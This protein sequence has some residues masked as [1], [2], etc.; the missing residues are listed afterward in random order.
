MTG[1]LVA[2]LMLF[3]LLPTALCEAGVPQSVS[4]TVLI[5]RSKS[6]TPLGPG[7]DSRSLKLDG[8]FYETVHGRTSLPAQLTAKQKNNELENEVTMTDGR[9]VKL[10]LKPDGRNFIIRLSAQPDSDI[11][12]WGLAVDAGPDEY[13]TGLMER[14]VDGPQQASW[15]SGIKAAM[16]LRGQKVDMILKPTTSVYAPFYLS[17][18]GYATFVKGNW[19]GAYDFCVTDSQR[20]KIEF[21][22]PSFEMKV[23]AADDPATLVRA[24]A[25]DAG[26]PF[27][28]PKWMFTPA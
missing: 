19:P 25:M 22:G 18:R 26:P 8:L 5:L 15:A 27:L 21:E 3:W 1:K 2:L 24:H 4:Q 6:L 28:P 12:K 9:V 17:S 10:S 23:Y 7:P 14:V 16:N 11:I 13:Y 20:V